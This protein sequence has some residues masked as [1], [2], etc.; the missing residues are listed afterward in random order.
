MAAALT[1]APNEP[2][3]LT[4]YLDTHQTERQH[5]MSTMFGALNRFIS[6]LDAAPEEQNSATQGAYGFQVLR[7]KNPEV[8]LDPWFDFIIGINGRTLVRECG[9]EERP[10]LMNENADRRSRMI[11][12]RICSRPRSAT[13]LAPR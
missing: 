9:E 6:R 10:E 1:Q 13:A 4:S 2:Q 11:R 8:P 3:H 7:N 5:I 12:I